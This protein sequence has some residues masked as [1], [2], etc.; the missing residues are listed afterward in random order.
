[1]D[2]YRECGHTHGVMP[3]TSSRGHCNKAGLRGRISAQSTSLTITPVDLP[4]GMPDGVWK[5]KTKVANRYL[6]LS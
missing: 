6:D 5:K 3:A 2:R 1:M 4:V